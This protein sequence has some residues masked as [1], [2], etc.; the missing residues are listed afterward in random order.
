MK[1][2]YY[3]LDEGRPTGPHSLIVLHQKADIHVIGPDSTVRPAESPDAPWIPIRLIPDL[4]AFLFPPKTPPVLASSRPAARTK[5][6][7]SDPTSRP[8][9]VESLLRDNTARLVASE[10][11]DP[12]AMSS[13]RA[14]RHRAF[15][16]TVL[17][18][19]APAWALYRF[20]PLPRTETTVTLLASAVAIASL[21]SY[22][23]IYHITDFRS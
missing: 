11:F 23:L 5:P 1:P 8:V 2:P 22:W 10:Y 14:R 16:F 20:G 9:E 21:L 19:A 3:L 17:A 13:R 15:L 4:H 7:G 18:L 12:G 6:P